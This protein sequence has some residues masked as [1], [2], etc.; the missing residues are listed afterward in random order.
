M[1]GSRVRFAISYKTNQPG[2]MVF[3][4]NYF[5]NFKVTINTENYEGAIGLNMSTKRR[6]VMA[7]GLHVGICH[8]KT[9]KEE[10]SF[11]IYSH[12]A[13]SCVLY[14]TFNKNEKYLGLSVGIKLQKDATQVK[15]LFIYKRNN[16]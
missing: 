6:Y 9:F 1:F 7:R 8:Q 15:E 5:H 13:N 11:D 16:R 2:L 3:T 4:R 14:M 10:Q 12:F